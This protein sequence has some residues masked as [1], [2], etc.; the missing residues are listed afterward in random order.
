MDLHHSFQRWLITKQFTTSDWEEI[1]RRIAVKKE[2][3]RKD[4]RK[5]FWKNIFSWI[6]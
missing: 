6:K 5:R 2:Q 3:I 4:K 1:D